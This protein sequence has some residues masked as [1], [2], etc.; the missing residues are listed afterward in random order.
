MG[1]HTKA[2]T[3]QKVASGADLELDKVFQV[4][5][6]FNRAFHLA[7]AAALYL[8]LVIRCDDGEADEATLAVRR[9]DFLHRGCQVAAAGEGFVTEL[10]RD[11]AIGHR[12]ANRIDVGVHAPVQP[13]ESKAFDFALQLSC[14]EVICWESLDSMSELAT[15]EG[16]VAD[17]DASD[18]FVI[19]HEQF[20]DAVQ[21]VDLA[22]AEASE[23]LDSEELAHLL[24]LVRGSVVIG[25]EAI[26]TAQFIE[27]QG[28]NFHLRP[29]LLHLSPHGS[30]LSEDGHGRVAELRANHLLLGRWPDD[31]L[32]LLELVALDAI[33]GARDHRL[34]ELER[35]VIGR[36][37]N[38]V[39]KPH[40]QGLLT[41]DTTIGILAKRGHLVVD[42]SLE[43]GQVCLAVLL[44]GVG[45]RW[46]VWASSCSG[47][48]NYFHSSFQLSLFVV[49][50]F[51]IFSS[52]KPSFYRSLP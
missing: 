30:D 28:L 21:T 50:K 15:E 41:L 42:L 52:Q 9:D 43:T 4:L 10:G 48:I 24:Q 5:K 51:V 35:E 39:S 6:D 49:C 3:L 22:L 2:D 38:L 12:K 31:S 32:E 46:L 36:L 33:P 34:R 1:A 20:C 13:S 26:A 14:K 19:L 29:K 27:S 11:S 17:D 23:R 37:E 40:L 47:L 18:I 7:L 8:E 25:G 16:R 45:D 44:H